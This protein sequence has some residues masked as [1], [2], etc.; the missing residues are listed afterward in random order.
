MFRPTTV[1]CLLAPLLAAWPASAP[2]DTRAVL[3]GLI[4]RSKTEV[5]G[6]ISGRSGQ[7]MRAGGTGGGPFPRSYFFRRGSGSAL[8]WLHKALVHGPEHRQQGP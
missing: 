2:A 8:F 6:R 7:D 1:A 4:G 3:S 5:I